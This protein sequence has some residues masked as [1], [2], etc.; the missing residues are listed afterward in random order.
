M[1]GIS[2]HTLC[3]ELLLGF[4]GIYILAIDATGVKLF[5]LIIHGWWQSISAAEQTRPNSATVH[6]TDLSFFLDQEGIAVRTGHHCT[7]P[8][9]KELK[10]AGSIR[11]SLYFYN[12]KEDIDIFIQKLVETTQMFESFNTEEGRLL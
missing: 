10:L 4:N 7:Q 8:L 2:S 9:H 5:K 1:K 11:A 3:N 12:S 6:A